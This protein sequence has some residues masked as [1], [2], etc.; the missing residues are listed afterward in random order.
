[1]FAMFAMLLSFFG[2]IGTSWS[3]EPRGITIFSKEKGLYTKVSNCCYFS[4]QIRKK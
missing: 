1:M 2:H 4:P 3:Q